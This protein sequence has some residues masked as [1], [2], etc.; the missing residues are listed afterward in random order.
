MGRYWLVLLQHGRNS[1]KQPKIEVYT[2]EYDVVFHRAS[3][4]YRGTSFSILTVSKQQ[5]RTRPALV[6]LYNGFETA[7]PPGDTR[8]CQD[9]ISELG[10]I[11]T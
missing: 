7:S 8:S 3:A 11:S 2:A 4:L 6:W 1:V 10:H 5:T 9:V